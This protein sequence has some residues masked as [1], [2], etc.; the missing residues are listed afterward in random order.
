MRACAPPCSWVYFSTS[1]SPIRY[2]FCKHCAASAFDYCTTS[3][4]LSLFFSLFVPL[5]ALFLS[6]TYLSLLDTCRHIRVL[7]F[8]CPFPPPPSCSHRENPSSHLLSL[9][10]LLYSLLPSFILRPSFD[11]T[12]PDRPVHVYSRNNYI[13]ARVFFS[14][15]RSYAA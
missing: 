13:P 9:S 2:L 5:A 3:S 7:R 6:F 14:L 12:R 1:I 11:L 4:S 8:F 10:I 15:D